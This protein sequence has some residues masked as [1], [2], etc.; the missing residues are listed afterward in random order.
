MKK[1]D[2]P[3]GKLL[4]EG[5]YTTVHE[6]PQDE[7]KVMKLMRKDW[8]EK[9]VKVFGW[10]IFSTKDE[11][12]HPL[13]NIHRVK[14]DLDFLQTHFKQ[15][16][17]RTTVA[18]EEGHIVTRQD[19]IIGPTL[20]ALPFTAACEFELREF[21]THVI[22]AYIQSMYKRGEEIHGIFPD[23]KAENFHYGI[24]ASDP[25]AKPRLY[26]ID[27]YPIEGCDAQDYIRRVLPMQRGRFPKHWQKV[28]TEFERSAERRICKHAAEIRH[29]VIK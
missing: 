8:K 18:Q 9:L 22:D 16:L 2:V 6:D 19:K 10:H 25:K 27:T 26:F 21:F 15:W 29:G 7:S 3:V 28:F 12:V 17:P 4:G 20:D 23:L 13:D 5:K 11:G 14:S 1:P 24:P